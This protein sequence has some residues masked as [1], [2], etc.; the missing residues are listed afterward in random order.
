MAKEKENVIREEETVQHDKAAD[1]NTNTN[2]RGKAKELMNKL[3]VN[4][5]YYSSD[6]YWF[7]N[8]NLAE[9]HAKAH[10]TDIKEFKN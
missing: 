8:K 9:L 5:L 7:T 4:E 2:L 1:E 6:G 3:R 10:S